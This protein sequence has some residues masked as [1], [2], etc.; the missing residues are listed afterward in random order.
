[1]KKKSVFA[2][3]KGENLGKLNTRKAKILADYMK[4]KSLGIAY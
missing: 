1:M 2:I 3:P 4:L